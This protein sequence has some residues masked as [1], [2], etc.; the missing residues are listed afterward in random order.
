MN[1][2]YLL[3]KIN[4]KN[5]NYSNEFNNLKA[6]DSEYKKNYGKN[7]NKN[8][9][10]NSNADNLSWRK[11]SNSYVNNNNNSEN[12]KENNH[13]NGINNN[14]NKKSNGNFVNEK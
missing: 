10:H 2:K 7:S 12:S 6:R 1:S 4:K 5:S 11:G 8:S 9:R 14:N 3:D 13:N